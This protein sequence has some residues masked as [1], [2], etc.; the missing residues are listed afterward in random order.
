MNEKEKKFVSTE[1]QKKAVTIAEWLV[2]KK[3]RDILALDV[4]KLSPW[5]ETQVI[6]TARGFRHAQALADAMLERLGEARFEY[7]GMEG[8]KTGHWILLDCNDVVVHIFQEDPRGY[9]NLEGLWAGAPTLYKQ[10]PEP[11]KPDDEDD[12]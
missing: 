1:P 8:Y 6:A 2:E 5:A 11:M 7:M 12:E 9:F 10:E 3:A 4:S